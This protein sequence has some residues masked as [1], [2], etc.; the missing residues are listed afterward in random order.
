MKIGTAVLLSFNHCGN[1]KTCRS[2]HPACCSNFEHL[3]I[4]ARHLDDNST[5]A[6]LSS[7]GRDVVTQFFGQSSLSRHSIV[8]QNSVVVCPEQDPEK[9]ALYAPL[10]CGFQTGAG[11]VL[12]A[13]KPSPQDTIAI[14]GA[15]AVG[16]AAVMAAKYLGI[17][18]V[19]VIDLI[20]E[21]LELAKELGATDVTKGG[22]DF[23]ERIHEVTDC[24][25]VRYAIDCTGVS[26]VLEQIQDCVACGG[27]VVI[28]GS[29]KPDFVMKI[30]LSQFLHVNKTIR[31]ICQGDSVPEKVGDMHFLLL[32]GAEFMT[33]DAY[34]VHT[35]ND[36]AAPCWKIPDREAL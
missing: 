25:G 18:N 35:R 22:G 19:I 4:T 7:D 26:S 20:D 9:L 24:E 33:D 8:S 12:N 29:P 23:V 28:V 11:T 14:F 6:K 17:E 21:K 36:R 16:L 1:C 31:G 15:G 30:P 27:T 34:T 3:N 32:S 13:L 10:G 2:D 5:C